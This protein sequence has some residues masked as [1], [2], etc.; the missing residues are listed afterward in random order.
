MLKVVIA[1]D[2]PMLAALFA[3][4][5]GLVGY[6]VIGIAASVEDT[7]GLIARQQPHVAIIDYRLGGGQRGTDI[8][9]LLNPASAPALLYLSGAPLQ[10][11]LTNLDGEGFIQKPVKLEDLDRALRA[12]WEIKT[13]GQAALELAPLCL[14][15]L[16]APAVRTLRAG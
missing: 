3:D 15:Q 9:P 10:D 4:Y 7:I 8:R 1:E 2:S 16:T 6:D 12:V 11:T 14:H 5:L 13:T